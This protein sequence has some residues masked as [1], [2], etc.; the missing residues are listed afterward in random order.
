M[1]TKDDNEPVKTKPANKPHVRIGT[2]GGHRPHIT[3]MIATMGAMS[4]AMGGSIVPPPSPPL[5]KPDDDSV[6]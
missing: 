4:M 3:M 1:N 2:I 5:P 6:V